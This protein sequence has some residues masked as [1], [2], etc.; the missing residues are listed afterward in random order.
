MTSVVVVH[1]AEAPGIQRMVAL[2]AD[3]EAFLRRQPWAKV[4][5][6]VGF[7]TVMECEACALMCQRASDASA[8]TRPQNGRRKHLRVLPSE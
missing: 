7:S 4:D 8:A 2:C 1:H 5:E 3:H 6:L